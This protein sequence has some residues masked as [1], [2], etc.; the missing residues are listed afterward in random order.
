MGLSLSSL[1]HLFAAKLV[2]S[3][4]SKGD[5]WIKVTGEDLLEVLGQLRS[6][7][8]LTFDWLIDLCGVDYLGRTPRFEVVIHLCSMKE[9]ER[10]RVHC[11]VPDESLTIPSVV[12]LWPGAN[13][14]EREAYDMYGIRF[15]GHPNLDRILNPLETSEFPQRKDYPL[16][17]SRETGGEG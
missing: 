11:L 13:W 8:D 7:P 3:G 15:K 12:S 17:G 9:A 14:H 2:D 4:D 1:R 6:H 10:I 5:T 16:R